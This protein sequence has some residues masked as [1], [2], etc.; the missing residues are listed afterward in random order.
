LSAEKTAVVDIL[1][2]KD[3]EAAALKSEPSHRA[4]DL[5]APAASI[6]TSVD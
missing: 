1:T 3:G 5:A 2:K 4:A 6:A